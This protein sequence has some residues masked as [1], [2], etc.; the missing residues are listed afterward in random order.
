MP[1]VSSIVWG[2]LVLSVDAILARVLNST[3]EKRTVED[4]ALLSI[5]ALKSVMNRVAKPFVSV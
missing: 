4:F 1:S 3:T 2:K 5:S